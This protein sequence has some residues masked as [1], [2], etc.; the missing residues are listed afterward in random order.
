MN[1]K[2]ARD[3]RMRYVAFCDVLGF[4]SA[5]TERFEDTV[6]VYATFMEQM[7]EWPFPKNA[8]I[9]IYSDSILIVSDDLSPVLHAVNNLWFAAMTNNWLIRGG[10]AYGKYWE[11][12]E[13]GNL[14]VV[15]DALVRAVKLEASVRHPVVAFCPEVKLGLNYWVAR[16]AHGLLQAPVLSFREISFVNPFN[17]YWFRSAE[18]RTKQMLEAFPEHEIKYRW[19]LD[20]VDAIDSQETLVPAEV[21]Q[22]LLDL[23]VIGPI[24]SLPAE[25]SG[26]I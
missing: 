11:Q 22:E 6:E 20:L 7:R 14:F 2:V 5:V 26:L 4:S 1:E 25:P 12:R 23:K 18:T 3:S 9:S 19:F 24:A 16:F 21:V 17:P 13:N 8:A 15:S 10:I